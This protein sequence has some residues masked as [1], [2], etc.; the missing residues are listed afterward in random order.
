MRL[1]LAAIGKALGSEVTDCT[2]LAGGDLGGASR[3]RLADGRNIVAKAGPLS[4]IEAGMLEAIRAAGAPCP[5]ILACDKDWFAMEWI[6]PEH[7]DDRWGALADTLAMLNEPAS[8]QYGW[9]H[10]YAFGAVPIANGRQS[11]WAA[12]WADNR[13]LCHVAFVAPAI[14]RRI[15]YV[16]ARIPDLLPSAPSPSL[17]HGDLWS[18]NVIFSGDRAWLIDPA[19]YYGHREVDWAMLTLFDHPPDHFFERVEPEAGWR[20]RQPV[21]RLWPLLVHLRLFGDSYRGAVERELAAL[22]F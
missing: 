3:I 2:P 4:V 5:A 7:T 13:L 18:G 15:E 22:G 9:H 14:G 20:E 17:L 1:D 6:E 12:F 16:S 19:S 10:D 21:Y 11:N 8:P